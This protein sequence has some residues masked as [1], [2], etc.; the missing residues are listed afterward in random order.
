VVAPREANP[1]LL[2]L[3]SVEHVVGNPHEQ[4]T[5]GTRM[6]L[7]GQDSVTLPVPSD[8]G[9]CRSIRF[10]S[11][12]SGARAVV[13][14]MKI[15]TIQ[16]TG[17][18]GNGWKTGFYLPLRTGLEVADQ[19]AGNEGAAYHPAVRVYRREGRIVDGKTIVVQTYDTRIEFPQ[20]LAPEEITVRHFHTTGEMTLLSVALERDPEHSPFERVFE[21]EEGRFPV[22]R[23]RDVLPR[24]R[25]VFAA[26]VFEAREDL[27]ERLQDPS[28]DPE[29]SVLLE[30]A[31]FPV[32]APAP[33]N[34][35]GTISRVERKPSRFSLDVDLSHDGIVVFSEV[36]YPGWKA[37]VDGDAA[38]ILRANGCLRCIPVPAGSHRVEMS[39]GPRG[40]FLGILSAFGSAGLMIAGAGLVWWSRKRELDTL[41]AEGAEQMSTKVLVVEDEADTRTVLAESLNYYG[42]EASTAKDGMEALEKLEK[43]KPDV[44]LLDMNLPVLSGWEA[45]QMMKADQALRDIPVIALTASTSVAS[46]A[47]ALSLGCADFIGKPCEPKD[48]VAKIKR[49]I[50]RQ[51]LI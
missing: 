10:Q 51:R 24:A 4:Q 37:R 36:F 41:L 46:E 49:V 32:P 23:N 12:L 44:V 2:N 35:T 18:D 26:E 45:L 5:S 40:L 1:R 17:R 21:S 30:Q 47:R 20:V 11:F 15:A 38:P 27:L 31:D 34:A 8:I 29:T 16:V 39:Y 43:S 42:F 33:G 28:W 13:R 19:L 14:G 22:Y 48:V 3:L 9:L 25:V 50:E 6:T 7:T